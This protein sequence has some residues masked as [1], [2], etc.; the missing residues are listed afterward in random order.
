[1]SVFPSP[2]TPHGTG[3]TLFGGVTLARPASH[4]SRLAVP[5]SAGGR[6]GLPVDQPLCGAHRLGAWFHAL[7]RES[8]HRGVR[9]ASARRLSAGAEPIRS[10]WRRWLVM[11]G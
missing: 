8:R 2:Q 9:G 1:A 10:C 4:T 3:I 11:G 5:Y 6:F 7:L